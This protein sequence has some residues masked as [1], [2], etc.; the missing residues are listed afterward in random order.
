MKGPWPRPQSLL[1]Y[2]PPAYIVDPPLV[3]IINYQGAL[4]TAE[5][6]HNAWSALFYARLAA[7]RLLG[8]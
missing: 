6:G 1:R 3:P 2:R 8:R 7:R 4:L 5:F